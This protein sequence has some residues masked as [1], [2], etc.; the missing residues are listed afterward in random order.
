MMMLTLECRECGRTAN[1]SGREARDIIEQVDVLGWD[2][3]PVGDGLGGLCPDCYS[4][5][6]GSE[7]VPDYLR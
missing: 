5:V 3:F 4:K 6:D 1:F 7:E 2:L